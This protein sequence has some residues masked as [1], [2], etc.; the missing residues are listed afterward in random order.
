MNYKVFG[1]KTGLRVSELALGVGNFG[2]RWGHGTE[3]AEARQILDAYAQAGGNFLDAA[4]SYQVGESEE[5]LGD[6]LGADRDHF[7]LATK[8]TFGVEHGQGGVLQSG[9]SRKNMMRSVEASLRRLKTDRIDLYWVHMADGVTPMEEIMRGLDDLVRA[10]KILYAGLSD[11]PAWRAAHAATLAELRGWAPLAG[12]QL[13]YSLAERTPDR[14]LLPMAEAFGLGVA[15]WSP[16][17]GGL[18]TGKYR[19]KADQGRL[20]GFNKN[21]IHEEDTAQKT[22]IVDAVL[23]IGAELGVSPSQVAIAWIRHK[24]AQAA[25]TVIPILGPRTLAQLTDNLGAMRVMLSAAQLQRL[26]EASAVA[27]GFPHDIIQKSRPLLDGGQTAR[28]EFPRLPVA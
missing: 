22:A 26:E 6:F 21:V 4:D 8:Y 25:T 14:E 27:L 3:R 16:L 17:A 18:L 19:E 20:V 15:L 10:G 7:V 9:N 28:I 24:A 23:A 2:M 5:Y 1:R 11:F 12:V 13:E